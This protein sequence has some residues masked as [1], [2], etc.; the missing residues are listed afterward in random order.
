MEASATASAVSC[1]DALGAGLDGV[2]GVLGATDDAAE[3]GLA[4]E[5]LDDLGTALGELLDGGEGLG[6]G[7]LHEAAV[8]GLGADGAGDLL[9]GGTGVVHGLGRPGCGPA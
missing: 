2:D 9:G 4:A 5:L 7:G 6:A 3:A 8:D 1:S